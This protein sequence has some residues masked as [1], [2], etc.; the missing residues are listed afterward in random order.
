LCRR[1]HAA[2]HL[3]TGNF[4]SANKQINRIIVGEQEIQTMTGPLPTSMPDLIAQ[5]AEAGDAEALRRLWESQARQL[6]DV[7]QKRLDPDQLDRSHTLQELRTYFEA[8][9]ALIDEALKKIQ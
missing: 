5:Y 4:C 1:R 3:A 8:N 7:E 2:S 6:L 9:M